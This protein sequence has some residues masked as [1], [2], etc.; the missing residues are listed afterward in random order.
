MGDVLHQVLVTIVGLEF[1]FACR[2]FLIALV[3]INLLL[4]PQRLGQVVNIERQ[5]Y[6]IFL[7]P[8]KHVPVCLLVHPLEVVVLRDVLQLSLCLLF[9]LLATTKVFTDG[10]FLAF[11]SLHI[12]LLYDKKALLISC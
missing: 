11:C 5:R 7:H 2:Y 10:A 1:A 3:V 4:R 6:K 12:F 8:V 9:L